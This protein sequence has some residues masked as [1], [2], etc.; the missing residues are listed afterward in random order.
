[1]DLKTPLSSRAS[2]VGL[3][4]LVMEPDMNCG[5]EA[6]AAVRELQLILQALGTCQGNMSG[7]EITFVAPPPRFAPSRYISKCELTLFSCMHPL[8]YF[9]LRGPDE[10]GR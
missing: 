4:E 2:G 7:M 10:S 8:T 9:P 1:M 6:A 5:E 3:M